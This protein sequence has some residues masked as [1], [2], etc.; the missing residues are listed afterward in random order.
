ML[1][2]HSMTRTTT[3]AAGVSTRRTGRKMATTRAGAR[4]RAPVTIVARA[5]SEDDARSSDAK[6]AVVA[7]VLAATVAL[8]SDGVMPEAAEAARSGGRVGGGSFRAS[9]RAAPRMRAQSRTAPPVGGYGYGYNSVFM[10]MP[11]MPMYGF[12]YGF[13]GMG[14]LFNLM[15]LFFI[16]N[17]LQGFLAQ[18]AE[19]AERMDARG[20]DDDEDF[21]PYDRRY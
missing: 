8:G 7:A 10:P 2:T 1:L 5:S 18:I 15:F 17:T 21:P 16:V 12:G 13:G 4:S 11:I 6:R 19:D 14:F 20:D 9:S 3:T